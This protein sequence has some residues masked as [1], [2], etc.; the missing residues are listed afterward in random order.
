MLVSNFG[1]NK[2]VKKCLKY[3]LNTFINVS[4]K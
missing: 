2:G 1:N 4:A 3:V